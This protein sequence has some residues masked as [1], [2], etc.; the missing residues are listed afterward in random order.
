MK[1]NNRED[2]AKLVFYSLIGIVVI[3]SAVAVGV[4]ALFTG[5][6]EAAD[7]YLSAGTIDISLDQQNPWNK[8]F[9][10][11]LEEEKKSDWINLTIFN[12]GTNPTKI[13]KIIEISEVESY[14]EKTNQS[15]KIRFNGCSSAWVLINDTNQTPINALF[16]IYDEEL[17][18]IKKLNRVI[19]DEELEK[20]PGQTEEY[21]YKFDEF[22]DNES[23]KI[24]AVYL[25]EQLIYNSNK[26]L[27]NIN[28]TIEASYLPTRIEYSL[29]I[30]KYNNNT[31]IEKNTIYS[32]E[33]TLEG[34]DQKKIYLETLNPGEYIKVSQKYTLKENT[35]TKGKI[36]YHIKLIADQINSDKNNKYFN[37]I[38]KALAQIKID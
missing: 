18:V 13:Y 28:K 14:I 25:E 4:S 7:G 2:I 32:G 10:V 36:N 6:N 22:E 15:D 30:E 21:L 9:L 12:Q 16:F 35:I 5:G 29:Y 17:D 33:K 27:Q 31:I 11:N 3:T 23:T 37:D 26:C 19:E 20:I 38:E 1:K 24:I 8:S 34:V